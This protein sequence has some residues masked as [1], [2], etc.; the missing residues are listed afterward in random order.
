MYATGA[1]IAAGAVLVSMFMPWGEL[2]RTEF[3]MTLDL[4]GGAPWPTGLKPSTTTIS[5]DGWH[6]TLRVGKLQIPN[7]VPVLAAGVIATLLWLDALAALATPIWL[8]LA[9]SLYGVV[10]PLLWLVVMT[11]ASEARVGIGPVFVVISFAATT[12]FVIQ[13]ARAKRTSSGRPALTE[14]LPT[15]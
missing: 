9:L 7:W 15:Q 3:H 1:A 5:G 14:G 10:H 11:V 4:G 12:Y 2:S 8:T 6:S 13:Q